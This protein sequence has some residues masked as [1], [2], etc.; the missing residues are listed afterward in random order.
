M[1]RSEFGGV[2]AAWIVQTTEPDEM[3]GT[4]T[5]ILSAGQTE[6]TIYDAPEGAV[7]TDLLD[8][9]GTAVSGVTVPAGAPYIPRFSG[10]D[11]VAVLWV[12]TEGG[13][14]LPVPP[15]QTTAGV[16]G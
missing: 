15:Y 14:W 12:Q 1:A 8:E 10:P 9:A 2:M 5:V 3:T 7:V 4:R 13:Q 6:L 16:S 11:G